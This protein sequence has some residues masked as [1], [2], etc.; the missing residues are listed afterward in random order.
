MAH[1]NQSKKAAIAPQIKAVL[2]K[3]RTKGTVAVRHYSTLVVN[4]KESELDLVGAANR[5]NAYISERRSYVQRYVV[6]DNF[7]VN[8]YHEVN[9]MREIGEDTI[10]DFY[11]ELIAA[12]NGA[13]TNFANYDN[14]DIQTDYFDVGWY[15][16]INVGKWNR[17]FV[18]TG[19]A[20]MEAA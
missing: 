15:I 3:Y 9:N 10:A 20:M 17:P 4:I 18:Y 8:P 19:A 6:E 1:M 5:W 11:E 13:G 12:M 14:S 16:D 2:K 7:D